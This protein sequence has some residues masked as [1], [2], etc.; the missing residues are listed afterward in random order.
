MKLTRFTVR[1]LMLAVAVLGLTLWLAL[2]AEK[3]LSGRAYDEWVDSPKPSGNSNHPAVPAL[4]ESTSG[5][6]K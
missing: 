3:H 1:R 4:I 5:A 6:A 2:L